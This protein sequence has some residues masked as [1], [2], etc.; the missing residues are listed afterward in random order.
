MQIGLL[1]SLRV[2]T[3]TGTEAE[4]TAP[5]QRVLIAALAVHVGRAVR[6]GQLAA[7]VWGDPPPARWRHALPPLIRR[8]RVALGTDGGRILT[9]RPGYR[10]DIEPQRIDIWEFD[11][12]RKDG[13]AATVEGDWGRAFKILT[14]AESLWRGAPFADI[15]SVQLLEWQEHLEHH[16]RDVRQARLEAEVRLSLLTARSALRDLKKVL[17]GDPA[18]E[19]LRWLLM[20]ALYRSGKQAEAQAEFR[21]AWQHSASE[22]GVRPGPAL[23][24]LNGR[25]IAGDPG[26]LSEP[27]S[28]PAA[29][30][31]I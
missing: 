28:D 22:L 29:V 4:I 13:L 12:L 15:E 3:V 9:S 23:Q 5:Q 30:G 10:L 24:A 20:L 14:A 16:H 2:V 17:T 6:A 11:E 25:I 31:A 7:A 21:D 8:L 1:G 19:H 26:L 27:F 18:S